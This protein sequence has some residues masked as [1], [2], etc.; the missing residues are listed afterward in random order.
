MGVECNKWADKL[1]YGSSRHTKHFDIVSQIWGANRAWF[2]TLTPEPVKKEVKKNRNKQNC[3]SGVRIGKEST[4]C[5]SLEWGLARDQQNGWVWSE[6][7]QSLERMPHNK[8]QKRLASSHIQ[9]FYTDGLFRGEEVRRG[10]GWE[11]GEHLLT[12]QEC[13]GDN[14]SIIDKWSAN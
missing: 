10:G 3:E 5:V 12:C 4:Q 8:A 6:D 13:N 1:I 2:N 11:G 9:P 7:W 14:L